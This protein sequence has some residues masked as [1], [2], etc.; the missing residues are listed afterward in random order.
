MNRFKQYIFFFIILFSLKGLSQY[1]YPSFGNT[2]SYIDNVEFQHIKNFGTGSDYYT[3]YPENDFCTHLT[4]GK[5]YLLSINMEYSYGNLSVAVWI[6]Y[7]DDKVFESNEL[8]LQ[9]T[10]QIYDYYAGA[11]HIPNDTNLIGKK[12]LR[13]IYGGNTLMFYL[14]TANSPFP[15]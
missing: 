4:I 7:D 5:Y 2:S 13:I 1:C 12:R 15:M 8:V 14:L 10:A 6:D 3:L 9:P 11:I